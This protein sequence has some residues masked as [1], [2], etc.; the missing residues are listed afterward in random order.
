MGFMTLQ[1]GKGRGASEVGA[2]PLVL[3]PV[4]KVR[5][6]VVAVQVCA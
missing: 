5:C 2:G 4:G 1:G 6:P 3:Q